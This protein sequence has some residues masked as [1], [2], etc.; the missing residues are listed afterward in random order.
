M[1][2]EKKSFQPM[3]G[4]LKTRLRKK[5]SKRELDDVT[6]DPEDWITKIYLL[7]DHLQ[8]LIIIIDNVEIMIH[9]LSK[10]PE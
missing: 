4:A 5:F 10:L 1:R 6:K 7:R 3:I 9:I 8:I 2:E